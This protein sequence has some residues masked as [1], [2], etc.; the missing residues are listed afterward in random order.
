MEFDSCGW[1]SGRLDPFGAA[2]SWSLFSPEPEARIDE[3]RWAHQAKVF[4]RAELTLVQKKI[5]PSGTI[6]I[7]DAVEVEIAPDGARKGAANAESRP[8]PASR[9]LVV[10]VPL[11]RAPAVRAAAAVGVAAIGGAGFDALLARARRL[12]QVRDAVSAGGDERAP[13]AVAAV[14]AAVLL[15]PVMPPGEATIFGVKGAR[16]RLEARGWR[17]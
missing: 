1:V 5:Y 10:T 15:A 14:L 3:H 7:A 4:F 13:L 6:P 9:V 11:D 16:A 2:D 8:M 17:T 12:W